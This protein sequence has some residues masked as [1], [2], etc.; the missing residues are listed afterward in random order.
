MA[1]V[2]KYFVRVEFI[3]Q[4]VYFLSFVWSTNPP[5]SRAERPTYA[6]T[7]VQDVYHTIMDE[8][9]FYLGA[10]ICTQTRIE[11]NYRI[12]LSCTHII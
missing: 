9:L 3:T 8:I 10:E 11:R 6:Y 4:L 12:L 5:R 7:H 2:I 1:E